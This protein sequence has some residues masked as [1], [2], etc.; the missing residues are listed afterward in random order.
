LTNARFPQ[1]APPLYGDAHAA[2][3]IAEALYSLTPA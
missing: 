3:R 2:T 1:D